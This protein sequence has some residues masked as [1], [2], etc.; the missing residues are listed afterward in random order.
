MVADYFDLYPRTGGGNA[1]S[2]AHPTAWKGL[3]P[4]GRGKPFANAD[5]ATPSRSIPARAGETAA[6]SASAARSRVYPRTGG[7]N[8]FILLLHIAIGGLSPHGRGKRG[9]SY[10]WGV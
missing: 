7:G 1:V 5:P 2:N 3:S 6:V 9:L 4:H 10:Q 8:S